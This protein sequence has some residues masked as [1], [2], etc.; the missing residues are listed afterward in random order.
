MLT[1]I[2]H[3]LN[4]N[5]EAKLCLKQYYL[6]LISNRAVEDFPAHWFLAILCF[7]IG[8]GPMTLHVP[9]ARVNRLSYG[10]RTEWSDN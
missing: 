6:S 9:V 10:Q 8:S 2:L 7:C 5:I 3:E 4:K 1:V